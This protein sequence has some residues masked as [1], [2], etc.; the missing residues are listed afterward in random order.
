M[1]LWLDCGIG[2]VDNKGWTPE[3]S[4]LMKP[5]GEKSSDLSM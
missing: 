1:R 4:A 2:K 3:L 5:F